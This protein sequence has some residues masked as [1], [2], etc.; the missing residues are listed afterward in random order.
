[1][2]R[3][4][5]IPFV[6]FAITIVVNAQ[7]LV[8]NYSLEDYDNCP[9]GPGELEQ[10]FPWTTPDSASPDYY[11]ACYIPFPMAPSMG[12]PDNIQ[13]SQDAHTGD[14]YAGIIA[15]DGSLGGIAGD[16]REYMRVQLTSPLTAGT[17]YQVR[18]WWSLAGKSPYSVEQIGILITDEYIN[19]FGGGQ[20]YTSALPYT[21]TVATA[22]SQLADTSNWVLHEECFIAD[23][24]EEWIYIG[25]FRDEN[26]VN[27]V[28]T[29]VTCDM[30]TGGCFAYYYI[31]DI[32]IEEGDCS[33]SPCDLTVTI[34]ASDPI[35]GEPDGSATANA[36]QGTEP[37]TYS[38]DNGDNTATITELS[39][40]NYSVTVTDYDGCTATASVLL[41][42]EDGPTLD[43][44]GINLTD[45]NCNNDDGSITGITVS[46]GAPSLSY[47]WENV[48]GTQVGT[49]IDLVDVSSGSYTLTVTDGNGCTDVA[50]P[51]T[52]NDIGGPEID[53]SGLIIVNE[54]CDQAN[55]SISGITVTAGNP[56]YTYSWY[57]SGQNIVGTDIDLDQLSEGEYILEVSDNSGCISQAGPYDVSNT[58]EPTVDFSIED[59]SCY[60]ASD[61]AINVSVSGGTQPYSYAW[62]TGETTQNLIDLGPGQYILTVTDANNCSVN[63]AW[64]ISSP[65][66]FQ[67]SF[68]ADTAICP[69][70]EVPLHI[71]T[72]GGTAPLTYHW[73]EFPTQTTAQLDVMPNVTTQYNVYVEDA[74]GCETEQLSCLVTV[75]ET[76]FLDLTT[77][78]SRCFESCDG[79]AWANITGGIPPFS[80]SWDY[81]GNYAN[82]L[83]AGTYD[84]VVTDDIGCTVNQVY[85]IDEPS[86]MSHNIYTE[87]ATCSYSQD[88]LA[89]VEVMG[90]T[91]PYQYFWSNGET[92]DSVVVGGGIHHLTVTDANMCV[93][94]LSADVDAP[95]PINVQGI[96]NSQICIGGTVNMSLSALG[97]T[98]PYD[99]HWTDNDGFN[100]YGDNVS[101]TPDTT[102]Q[103]QVNVAD[104]KGCE[105][106]YD[107]TV[108][109]HPSL[110]LDVIYPDQDSICPGESITLYTGVSGGNGGPYQLFYNETQ[111]IPSP[112]T[113]YPP[114]SGWITV[115]ASDACQTPSVTDSV[116]IH[117]WETPQNNFISDIVGGCPPLKVHF[118]EIN[119]QAGASYEWNFGDDKFSFERN[120]IHIYQNSGLFS[121]SLKIIDEN[122]CLSLREK[123][124]MI[125]VYPQPEIDFYTQPNEI[126]MLNPMVE[127]VSITQFTD[128]LYWHFGDGDSTEYSAQSIRHNYDGIGEYE[129]VLMGSNSFGCRDTAYKTIKVRDF[130]SFYAPTAFTPN[131][132]GHNDCFSVCGNGIDPNAFSMNIYNRWGELVFETESFMND[133][134]A[135][136]EGS[137]DGT[138]QGNVIKGDELLK[139]GIYSWYVEFKDI[140]GI[141]YRYDGVIY[142]IR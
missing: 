20:D 89:W 40:G 124:N 63:D 66:E 8:P 101:L 77:E 22:G 83:C 62:N 53:D 73:L 3:L 57:D 125:H 1:M 104:I 99:F 96:H 135:C 129:I 84:L 51:F 64:N 97:G 45:A 7:N 122:G 128:S 25:N 11:N 60:G 81:S 54:N 126:S 138:F 113:I 71:V 10:A 18:F 87:A 46:G 14:A 69:G 118:N 24:G 17:E 139:S 30:Q 137:W 74:N 59:I 119:N 58:P 23:G 49:N 21:P 92:N 31:D 106:Q 68:N 39:N 94:E 91:P 107:F 19:Y 56:P 103:Y 15:Y 116:Y 12:V 42:G 108:N 61:G 131:Y 133:C 120:P 2:K 142:L 76:M 47:S 100:W 26:D 43:A 79:Q 105:A 109:V 93:L 114:E 98:F 13:G 78:D 134:S 72:N 48:S 32:S 44:T 55:G 112:A 9:M 75:S 52:I 86:D 41:S 37:Y 117:V 85:Q 115:T 33:S 123:P 90:G 102:T 130:F 27:F 132:D 29:G 140:T 67:I 36:S 4:I 88:G 127:F 65:D 95:I 38:W 110:S 5:I 111:I 141:D 121:V 35:C 50:G 28:A 34:D 6:L 70:D 80:Y 82:G 16:Y 136:G